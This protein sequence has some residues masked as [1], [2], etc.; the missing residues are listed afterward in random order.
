MNILNLTQHQATPEQ[1]NAGVIEPTN[2]KLVQD[3][4]T[5]TH[6]P[7]QDDIIAKADALAEIAKEHDVSYAMIGGVPYLMPWLELAL[8]NV[9]I[10]PLYAYSERV[11]I[12]HTNDK[13]E[14]IKQSVFKHIGFVG[15]I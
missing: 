1:V 4:L 11:S 6:L 14:T 7:T 5:F 12:E 10:T 8:S 3:L 9:G 13:G 2:K 15:L